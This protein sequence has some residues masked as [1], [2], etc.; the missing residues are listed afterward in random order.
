MAVHTS[1][2]LIAATVNS[3]R[4]PTKAPALMP[5]DMNAVTGVGAPS[6]TSGAHQWKGTAAI[7]KPK[8]TATRTRATITRPLCA[9]APRLFRPAA[10][11]A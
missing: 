4:K 10:M 3:F 8:P 2:A 7:L 6:Y 9:S 1:G 11:L 5:T